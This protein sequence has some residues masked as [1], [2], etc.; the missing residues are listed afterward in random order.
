LA[1]FAQFI[2]KT[3]HIS[4]Q[5]L[6]IKSIDEAINWLSVEQSLYWQN[7]Y[8]WE[9]PVKKR[10]Q[11]MGQDSIFLLIINAIVPY[12]F[13]YGQYFDLPELMD[14]ALHLLSLVSPENNTI[15]HKWAELGLKPKDAYESQGMIGLYT[16]YCQVKKCLECPIGQHVMQ[17]G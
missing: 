17:N 7:H 4:S 1:Q 10:M 5:T 6:E 3:A 12:Q 2:Q 8:T 16:Q 11:G 14:S 9:Q 15:V 13:F